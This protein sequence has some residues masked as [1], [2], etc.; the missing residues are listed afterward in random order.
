MLKTPIMWAAGLGL[1]VVLSS[2][3]QAGPTTPGGGAGANQSRDGQTS[4][5]QPQRLGGALSLFADL[6]LTDAQRAQLVAIA[7]KY[8]AQWP[9]APIDRIRELLTAETVDAAAL[10]AALTAPPAADPRL[11]LLSAMLVEAR[12]VLTDAQRA[13]LV[14]QLHA[15]TIPAPTAKPAPTDA[16]RATWLDKASQRL[17]MTE[18]QKAAFSAYLEQQRATDAGQPATVDQSARRDAMVRFFQ[19]GEAAALNALE[20]TPA[21]PVAVEALVNLAT[22]L[23]QA[24]RQALFGERQ[25][26]PRH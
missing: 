12:A 17:S 3:G 19:T 8:R 15:V 24:Q 10:R 13:T 6:D 18:D 7:E 16:D 4:A 14:Q 2:C 11:P 5:G 23:N 20:P 26:R 21:P 9:A 1:V 25:N 22:K